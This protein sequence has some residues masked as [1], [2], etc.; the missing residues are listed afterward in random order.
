MGDLSRRFR[1]VPLAA[2]ALTTGCLFGSNSTVKRTGSDV[3][4]ATFEQIQPGTTTAAWVRATLGEP[5]TVSRDAHGEVWAYAC[6]EHVES[7]GYVFL[8]FGGSNTTE[9]TRRAFVE[10]R[11]GT[12]VRKWH[13]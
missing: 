6:T 2:L 5:T 11:D 3:S 7:D 8:I 12:V 9:T 10:L 1:L 4:P 13:G